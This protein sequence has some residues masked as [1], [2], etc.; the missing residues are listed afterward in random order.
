[1]ASA[2]LAHCLRNLVICIMSCGQTK[3]LMIVKRD[4]YRWFK[5]CPTEYGHGFA[6]LER[7]DQAQSDAVIRL[8]DRRQRTPEH[9]TC[10]EID[11]MYCRVCMSSQIL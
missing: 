9:G 8:H 10:L 2:L 1:M 4:R 3:I 5:R 11:E 6:V 7:A